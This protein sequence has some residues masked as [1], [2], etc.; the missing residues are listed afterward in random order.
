M[1]VKSK[2]CLIESV[3]INSINILKIIFNEK[4]I[5]NNEIEGVDEQEEIAIEQKIISKFE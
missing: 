4:C 2:Q 5:Y 1:K 3:F